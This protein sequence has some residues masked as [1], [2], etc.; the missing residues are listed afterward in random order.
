[1]TGAGFTVRRRAPLGIAVGASAIREG[2]GSTARLL[3]IAHAVERLVEAGI[4]P[5]Y[6]E[7]ARRLGISHVRMSEIM[8]L[9]QLA[10]EIQEAILDGRLATTERALRAVC[11]LL[12]WDDQRAALARMQRPA[13]SSAK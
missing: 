10:P 9:L 5:S 6:S 3:A 2:V 12:G 4:L 11:R 8:A 1:M 7:A 13:H